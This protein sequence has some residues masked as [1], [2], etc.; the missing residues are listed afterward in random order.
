[1]QNIAAS[2][3]GLNQPETGCF[4]QAGQ[5]KRAD[6]GQA[7][8]ADHDPGSENNQ[9]VHKVR[10]QER[11]GQRPAPFTEYPCETGRSERHST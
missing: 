11:R 6:P 8:G 7:L 3:A 4:I 10:R 1:M 5:T 2:L 9:I